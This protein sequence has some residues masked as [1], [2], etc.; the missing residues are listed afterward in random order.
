MSLEPLETDPD[1]VA[2]RKAQAEGRRRALI[3]GSLFGLVFFVSGALAV[4][5]MVLLAG[6]DEKSRQERLAAY[7]AG[8]TVWV[9]RNDRIDRTAPSPVLPL[10]A[11]G[12]VGLV[13]FAVG[14]ALVLRDSTYL[15]GLRAIA[16]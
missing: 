5:T 7:K 11:G 4:G 15:N 1:I 16:R 14:S 9:G 13:S 2:F 6:A 8:E 12:L 10:V 3:R